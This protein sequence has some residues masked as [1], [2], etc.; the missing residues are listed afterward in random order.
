LPELSLKR[1]FWVTPEGSLLWIKAAI[2]QGVKQ[3]V[4]D[5]VP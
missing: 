3:N 2:A 5:Q 4:F 1:A